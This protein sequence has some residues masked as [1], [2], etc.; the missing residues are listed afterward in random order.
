[1]SDEK[2]A[3]FGAVLPS[4]Q[5]AVASPPSAKRASMRLRLLVLSL[6]FFLT[7]NVCER[8]Q[9]RSDSSVNIRHSCHSGNH[10]R[11]HWKSCGEGI[12]GYE[13]ANVTV[14]LDYHNTSDSRTIS[15][16]VT[17][18]SAPDRANR[19]AWSLHAE[20]GRVA[21]AGT[22]RAPSSSTLADQVS[23]SNPSCV[24]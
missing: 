17:R 22:V 1:M 5:W 9:S 18:F 8:L 3:S 4:Y 6:A 20:K 14:P 21:D 19:Y 7:Y 23:C 15:I 12:E 16:A 13:C 24:S 10:G 2:A 11:V